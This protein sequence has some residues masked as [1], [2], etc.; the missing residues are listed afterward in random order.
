MSDIQYFKRMH[1][2]VGGSPVPGLPDL[3]RGHSM[4]G[5]RS[6]HLY[7]ALYSLTFNVSPTPNLR[8]II[9]RRYRVTYHDRHLCLGSGAQFNF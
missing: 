3:L 7:S 4:S 2:P 6:C 5:G 8:G 1:H 9:E